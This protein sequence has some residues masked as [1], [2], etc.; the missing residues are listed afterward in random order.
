VRALP[1]RAPRPQNA[2]LWRPLASSSSDEAL[3][4][5]AARRC[6]FCS[7]GED[8]DVDPRLSETMHSIVRHWRR[9]PDPSSASSGADVP[10]EAAASDSHSE[11]EQSPHARCCPTCGADWKS[12]DSL[13]ALRAEYAARASALDRKRVTTDEEIATLL[14]RYSSD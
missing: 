9:S 11:G 8:S 4:K 14:S 6:K 13:G 2:P 5:P 3:V 7:R 1:P 12:S 10:P